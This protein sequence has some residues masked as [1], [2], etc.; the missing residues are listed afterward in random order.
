MLGPSTPCTV[1]IFTSTTAEAPHATASALI[2]AKALCQPAACP[3]VQ[4]RPY[5]YQQ[6]PLT[7]ATGRTPW[8]RASRSS[9]AVIVE[10]HG[11][12]PAAAPSSRACT[13]GGSRPLA[14]AVSQAAWR[15]FASAWP[16]GVE[17]DPPPRP[18]SDAKDMPSDPSSAQRK[19]CSTSAADPPASAKPCT[20]S[21]TPASH[22]G[23]L[24]GV[25]LMTT[26]R[27]DLARVAVTPPCANAN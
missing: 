13:K 10:I 8:L 20:S 26:P 9:A 17:V 4:L 15:T 11:V 5:W 1:R 21:R 12:R 2:R 19:P 6:V 27:T 23:T 25:V 24:T 7:I 22:S 16:A 3:S 18:N 14:N